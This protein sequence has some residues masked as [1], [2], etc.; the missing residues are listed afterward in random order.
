M[1]DASPQ[2]QPGA[3]T[4]LA[5]SVLFGES[6]VEQADGGLLASLERSPQTWG[7]LLLSLWELQPRN[8]QPVPASKPSVSP[9]P[10]RERVAEPARVAPFARPAPPAAVRAT[11][12]PALEMFD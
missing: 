12:A 10:S 4:R 3:A 11:P 6:F 8:G 2:T 1:V 5:L 9:S 7:S